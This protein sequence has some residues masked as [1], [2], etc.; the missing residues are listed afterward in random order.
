MTGRKRDYYE[1]LGLSR[2]ADENAIK[3]AY[4]KLAKKYHPDTNAGSARAEELF[5]E[6][7]EAYEVLSDPEKKK[8]YDRFGHAAFDGSMAGGPGDGQGA[9]GYGGPESGGFYQEFHFGGDDDMDDILKRFFGGGFGSASGAGSGSGFYRNGSA[10]FGGRDGA[11]LQAE[12]TVSFDEAAFGCEKT[13]NLTDPSG[14]QGKSRTVKVRIPA[15]IDTGKTIRLRG[16]GM[17]GRGGG[18]DGNLLLKVTVAEKPGFE[19]RGQD[20]YTTISIPY[21]KAVFGGETTV[22]T[23]YGTSRCRIP[24]GVQS[25][26]KLRLRGKGIVSMNDPK[27]YGDQYVVVQIQVPR[28]LS[29]AAKRKLREFEKLCGGEG[30]SVA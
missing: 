26:T 7:T 2:D 27:S 12:I 30:R 13:V 24:E 3:R 28:N 11:D 22:Q 14:Q 29:E 15:G 16:Q 8:L 4:R 23:L 20:V 19:R 5:K 18:S 1:V 25:G 9:Y 6:V 17:P 21:T 10:G